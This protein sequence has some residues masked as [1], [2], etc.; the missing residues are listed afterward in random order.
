MLPALGSAGVSTST[1]LSYCCGNNGVTYISY[2]CASSAYAIPTVIDGAGCPACGSLCMGIS[3]STIASTY[4]G[5][6]PGCLA[7]QRC[8]FPQAPT[9][10]QAS[11]MCVANGAAS[12]LSQYARYLC[13]MSTRLLSKID[14]SNVKLTT[15]CVSF[16]LCLM[17]AMGYKR[18]VTSTTYDID[19][20]ACPWTS[21][22]NCGTGG[23]AIAYDLSFCGL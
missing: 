5:A 22:L 12:A 16:K 3:G 11:Q 18:L 23:T 8:T 19:N 9:A 10:S 17:E 6:L 1:W 4:G 2:Y 7:K 21:K 13:S 15:A 20:A 14:N